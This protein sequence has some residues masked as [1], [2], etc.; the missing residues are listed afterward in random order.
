MPSS[1]GV[2]PE[3]D[4]RETPPAARRVRGRGSASTVQRYMGL[5]IL[6]ALFA[7]WTVTLPGQFLTQENLLSV[8]NNETVTVLV[9]LGILFPLAAGVFDISIAG[10][11][12][13]S[14]TTV[15]LMFQ[16]T[17]GGMPV[18]LAV[19]L[20]LFMATAA[21]AL[22][23]AL[24]V[25][26]KM[27][28]FITTLA[29]SSLFVGLSTLL[30]GGVVVS[31]S[32]PDGFTDIGRTE[33]AGVPLPVLYVIVLGGLVWYVLGATPF[34]RMLYATGQAREAARLAGIPVGRV[35]FV[36]YIVSALFA[37]VAGIVFCSRIGAGVPNV[38]A[39][40]L[41]PTYA[42]AFLGSTM[43]LPGRF[44]V[45][46]LFVAVLLLAVG[47]NG[48]LLHGATTWVVSTFQ[49]GT[50]VIAVALSNLRS[51]RNGPART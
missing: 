10:V 28:P 38:G 42:A 37:A 49:G 32:I 36:A 44:N 27:D 45:P 7:V 20:T 46:G 21:G 35:L 6:A 39:Q 50:L 34:G 22:N 51:R 25:W 43:I 3:A 47:I 41:L 29:T 23:A 19:V 15:T 5:A 13:L 1:L 24:V 12:T 30:S 31:E 48:L 8:L 4:G 33:L 16:W 14:V 26:V 18:V 9:A 17:D 2:M 11:L 40:Y